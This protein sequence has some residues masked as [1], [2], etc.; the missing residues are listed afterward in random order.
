M[1]T[2]LAFAIP[3]V[4]GRVVGAWLHNECVSDQSVSRSA[5]RARE[6]FNVQTTI[7]GN[8]EWLL[9]GRPIARVVY[10]LDTPA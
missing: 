5:K 6:L 9:I 4:I 10:D 1:Q 7:A 3:Y 8:Q 2:L